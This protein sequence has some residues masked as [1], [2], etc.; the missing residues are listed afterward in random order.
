MIMLV[1]INNNRFTVNTAT[2]CA[3][4]VG[5][6]EDD[7]EAL[8]S[9]CLA[10][11]KVQLDEDMVRTVK[12]I[13]KNRNVPVSYMR[14]IRGGMPWDHAF[15]GRLCHATGYEVSMADDNGT[16]W[17][18]YYDSTNDTYYYGR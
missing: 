17:N 4:P 8:R 16:W 14:D 11:R 15:D 18:E 10:S 6:D 3:A 2:W 1:N 7:Y 12:R 13:T 5:D 9:H